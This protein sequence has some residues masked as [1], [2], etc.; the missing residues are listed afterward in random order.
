MMRYNDITAQYQR[1]S[2]GTI[3]S[4]HGGSLTEQRRYIWNMLGSVQDLC[5]YIDWE[6]QFSKYTPPPHYTH[7]LCVSVAHRQQIAS[8]IEIVQTHID[9]NTIVLDPFQEIDAIPIGW[10][11]SSITDL[12]RKYKFTLYLLFDP[13]HKPL[14]QA[15][16]YID[17]RRCPIRF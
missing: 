12:V 16:V 17:L 9:I 6:D 4:F 8:I 2:S 7:V 3:I 10:M 11:Y 14:F 1:K 15:Q 5:L 13:E